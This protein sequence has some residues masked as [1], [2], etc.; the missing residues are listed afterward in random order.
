MLVRRIYAAGILYLIALSLNS[1]M[2]RFFRP[3]ITA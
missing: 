3:A 1:T 2:P